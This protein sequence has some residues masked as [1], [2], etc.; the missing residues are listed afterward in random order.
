MASALRVSPTL[1]VIRV[2]KQIR[3]KDLAEAVGVTP[4]AIHDYERG[5]RQPVMEKAER[6][7]SALGISLNDYHRLWSEVHA[8][9]DEAAKAAVQ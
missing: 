8:A 7:A 6:H 9:R 4:K 1:R 3:V 5:L 2:A